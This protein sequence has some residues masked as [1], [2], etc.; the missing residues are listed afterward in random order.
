MFAHAPGCGPK[1]AYEILPTSTQAVIWLPDSD[2]LTDRWSKTQ[3]AKLADDPQVKSFWQDQQ[4]E[5]E[6]SLPTL[7]GKLHIQPPCLSGS[8]RADK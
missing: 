2:V 1:P 8:G 7:A 4:G 6:E 3:L 5:I